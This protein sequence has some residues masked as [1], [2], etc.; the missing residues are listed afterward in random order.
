MSHRDILADL[1][2]LALG[3]RL[4][5]L[6]ER[7]LADASRIH[8]DDVDVVPPGQFPLVAALDRYGPMTVNDAASAIGVSQPVATRAA[9]EA[10]RVGLVEAVAN[11]EDRRF[12]TLTLTERGQERVA[13]LKLS[14]WPR[15]EAAA[16]GLLAGFGEEFLE[17]VAALESRLE[18]QSLRDRYERL[19]F[20]IVPYRDELAPEFLVITR[21]WIEAMDTVEPH[22]LNALENPRAEILQRGGRIFFVQGGDGNVLG[23]CALEKKQEGL[24]ELSKIAVRSAARGRGAGEFLLRGVLRQ[25]EELYPG[26]QLFLLI[27]RRGEAALP[28]FRKVGFEIDTALLKQL[29]LSSG[30]TRVALR[31]RGFGSE[32]TSSSKL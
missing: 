29:G 25:A 22:D 18:E 14:N 26:A 6:S 30:R 15:V 1:G 2:P 11:P 5:R 21:E 7:L 13:D 24:M 32:A 10:S 9:A 19:P 16:R 23:T 4:K 20:R 12:R 3:S 28:L 8:R 17:C 27:G 31:F